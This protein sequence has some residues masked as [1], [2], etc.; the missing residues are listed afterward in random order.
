[1]SQTLEQI[2][3]PPEIPSEAAPGH[4]ATLIIATLSLSV[5]LIVA[6]VASLNTAIPSIGR[7]LQAS[8]SQMQWIIDSYAIAL[9][10]LLLPAG[11]LG[12]RFGRKRLMVIGYVGFVVSMIWAGST[13][14]INSLIAARGLGGAFSALIFPGTL[15]TIT[16]VI[17][18]SRRS[19]AIAAWTV[20]ASLGGV[21]GSIGAGALLEGFEFSSIFIATAIAGVIVGAMTFLFVPET[22]DPEESNLDPLGSL[23]SVIGIG[24]LT[25]AIIEGPVKGWTSGLVTSSFGV[26]AVALA[27]FVLWELRT[28]SP[29]FD[30]RLFKLRGFSS[31]AVSIFTQ[32]FVA[33][34]FFF[35]TA[36]YLAFVSGYS[37]LQIGLSFIPL[38]FS[39][40]LASA[41]APA[42]ANRFG[43]AIVGGG[44]LVVLAAGSVLLTFLEVDSGFV[45]YAVA[46]MVFGAGMGLASPPATEAIVEA[47]PAE[48]QGVASA[49][50]DVGRELGGALGIALVGAMLSSGYR[51]AIEDTAGQLP[52]GLAD[53]LAE[54]PGIG[55]NAAAQ[56]GADAPAMV[57][58]I[59][60]AVVDGYGFAMWISAAVAAAGAVYVMFRTPPAG[61]ESVALDNGQTADPVLIGAEDLT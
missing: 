31:G 10:A 35:V 13:T 29:L 42:L 11:A 7:E 5:T 41:A 22:S 54:S 39:I 47:L 24:I 15:S 20:S 59:Q 8:A 3:D 4:S 48:K 44:G 55:L 2:I 17:P 58:L 46:V 33:F 14:D 50:N 45:A 23:L 34:G 27:T 1:M 21:G 53:S 12:D 61:A 40:P 19:Q 9:A 43:R 28:D 57:A 38:G 36:Q 60:E 56:A 6:G 16:T 26:A 49:I 18:A 25:F 30:V 52:S 51:S 37:P 32:F